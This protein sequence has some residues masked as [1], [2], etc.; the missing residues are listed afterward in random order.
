MKEYRFRINGKEFTSSV[1]GF[2]NG[3]ATVTVNGRTY[4]VE[5]DNGC[6]ASAEK[7]AAAG[8]TA[9]ASADVDG[10]VRSPLPGVI[11]GVFADR[12]QRL[13]KGQRIAVLE[14]MKMENDI[15]APCDGTLVSLSVRSGDSVLEGAEIA[16]V[17]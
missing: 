13:K 9:A 15:L 17:G 5:V 12:G 2:E 16:V 14:A 6:D 3:V 7:S 8:G 4:S 11:T 1:D 10:V